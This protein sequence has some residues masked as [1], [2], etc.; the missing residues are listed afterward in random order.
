MAEI[1]EV[2][3]IS[4][5][6]LDL[7]REA[8][9]ETAE[10]LASRSPT[11]ILS[12]LE[13]AS[14]GKAIP[15]RVPSEAMVRIWRKAAESMVRAKGEVAATPT[16]TEVRHADLQ[17]AGI[18]VGAMPVAKVLDDAPPPADGSAADVAL[19]EPMAKDTAAGSGGSGARS[20]SQSADRRGSSRPPREATEKPDAAETGRRGKSRKA[21]EK[22]ASPQQG[23]G[24]E[25]GFRAIDEAR[26]G[27]PPVERRNR[28]MSHPEAGRVR[29][30]AAITTFCMLASVL[31]TGAIATI[32][33]LAVFYKWHFHWTVSL[34]LLVYPLCLFLY[35]GIGTKAR[36]RLCGQRLFVPRHCLKHE[37]ASRSI[38]GYTFAMARDAMLLANYRCMLCGT[39]TRLRD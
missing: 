11:E 27:E 29:L 36:C 1:S 16:A 38:F 5:P 20:G 10:A 6:A 25:R 4:G 14:R 35:L 18:D 30:A 13:R 17:S 23:R 33:V 31:T 12:A 8:G 37:R 2:P 19:P 26:Q 28:G 32:L 39:K 15:V 24:T 3:G 7:F 34:L 21:R 9:F 22:A